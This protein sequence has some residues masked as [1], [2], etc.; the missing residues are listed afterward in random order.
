MALQADLARFWEIKDRP[1]IQHI[2]E[3]DRRC[4]EHF[5]TQV[6]R[7][8]EGGYIVTLP[9][10]DQLPSLGSSKGLAMKRLA[11]LNRQFQRDKR[12]KAE[13]RAVL[14]DY[15]NQ[16]HMLRIRTDNADDSGYYLPHHDV[17]KVSSETT[18][19]RVVFNGSAA[20]N[21]GVSLNDSLY[22]GL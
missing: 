12:F 15:L 13:Y 5:I 8:S 22:T 17:I 7:T 10:N 1:S 16:G 14:Q 18:K 21:T 6:R 2:S 4:K 11:S 9:F 19:L 3:A 20:S